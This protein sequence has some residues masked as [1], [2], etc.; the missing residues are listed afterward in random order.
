MAMEMVPAMETDMGGDRVEVVGVE[1]EEV[2]VEV[3]EVVELA[4][5]QNSK[6]K[7]Y[8]CFSVTFRNRTL[9]FEW[10]VV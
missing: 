10:W 1:E 7:V 9:I 2:V 8:M 6:Y 5:N 4:N 3:A